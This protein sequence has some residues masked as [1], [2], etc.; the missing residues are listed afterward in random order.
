MVMKNINEAYRMKVLAGLISESEEAKNQIQVWFDLD[1][2]LADMQSSLEMDETHNKYKDE[3]NAAL[4][5]DFPELM[6]LGN[7]ELKQAINDALKANPN[8]VKMKSLKK[9]YKNYNNYIFAV[10]SKPN[11]YFHMNLMPGAEQL[12]KDAYRITGVKPN[13]LSSPVGN[14]KDKKNPSVFEKKQWVYINF[15]NKIAYLAQKYFGDTIAYW[16]NKSFGGL[17]NKINITSD[18]GAVVRSKYDILID[19]RQKYV[20]KFI[21]AGGSAILYKNAEDAAEKLREL[22]IQLTSEE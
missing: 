1:G 16:I 17:I 15:S 3:L 18:K 20:D 12:V 19:D 2:V 10:A 22:Y 4:M 6:S 8:D 11:F 13:I 5:S 21:K 14:E 9:K 7:D